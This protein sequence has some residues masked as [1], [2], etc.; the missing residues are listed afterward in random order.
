[1]L[2]GMVS[3]FIKP[4]L[5]FFK[6]T[7]AIINNYSKH[8]IRDILRLIPKLGKCSISLKLYGKQN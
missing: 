2:P 8:F 3:L 5:A 6:I 7:S 1:M 4:H